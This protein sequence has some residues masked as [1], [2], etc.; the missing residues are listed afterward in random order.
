[1]LVCSLTLSN[2]STHDGSLSPNAIALWLKGVYE[3]EGHTHQAT[4][5]SLRVSSWESSLGLA[6][7]S[8]GNTGSVV[9]ALS[10]LS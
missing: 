5:Q 8:V 4:Q 2:K 1:M 9:K 10:V 3:L 6:S 7:S